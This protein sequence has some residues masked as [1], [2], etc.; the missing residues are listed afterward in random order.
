MAK[1]IVSVFDD[2]TSAQSAVHELQAAGVSPN[3]IRL[4]SN[5]EAT[6]AARKGSRAEQGE[7]GWTDKVV[8]FFGSL[9]ED[10][11]DKSQASTYAEAW[12][13]GHYLVIAD[14]ESA[15]VDRAVA[16]LNRL[17]TVD[18]GRRAEHWKKTGFTGAYDLKAAPYTAEQRKRELAEY[19]ETK[20]VPVVQEELLVGK[21]V[22][23][24]GG[25]RVHSYVHERPVE[26]VVRLRE[27]RVNVERRPANR[28]VQ[29]GDIA[30]Q[31]RTVDVTAQGEEAVAAKKPR[32]VEEVVVSKSATQREETVRDTVRREDVDVER[33]EETDAKAAAQRPATARPTSPSTHR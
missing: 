8:D 20:A 27:E 12:R 14:V 33:I 29:P 15:Q 13:R 16:I 31:E 2:A 10:E 25:V 3:H 28:A 26:E 18:L 5:S 11:D 9:F 32:V 4:T 30:F 21:Q 24:R 23:Q 7:Q 17:G 6:E 19:G 1:T 22:V